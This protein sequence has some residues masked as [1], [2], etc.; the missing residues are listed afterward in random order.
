MIFGHVRNR[1]ASYRFIALVIS[2]FRLRATPARRDSHHH[3]HRRELCNIAT[4]F[5]VDLPPLYFTHLACYSFCRY[6][7]RSLQSL[8]TSRW[9][10]STIAFDIG[11]GVE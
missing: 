9:A 11:D 1:D 5:N 8:A 10:G 6:Q 2:S 3:Q 4:L 7:K